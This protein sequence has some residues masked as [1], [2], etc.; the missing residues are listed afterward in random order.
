MPIGES[1]SGAPEPF[2]GSSHPFGVFMHDLNS[3]QMLLRITQI[4]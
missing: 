1:L 4:S 3:K 2:Q